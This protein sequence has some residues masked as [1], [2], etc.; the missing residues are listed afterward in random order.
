MEKLKEEQGKYSFNF[1]WVLYI[2]III[3]IGIIPLVMRLTLVDVREVDY[4]T[5][6][7]QGQIVDIFS[8]YKAGMLMATVAAMLLILF[9][10]FNKKNIKVDHSFK[11]MSI[12]A[13]VYGLF[14]IIS[15]SLSQYSEIAWWGVPDRAEGA[16]VLIAYLILMYYTYYMIQK[17]QHI[18]YIIV[19][20]VI[21]TLIVSV[22][23]IFQYI[24]EDLFLTTDL[25]KQ[26][27]VPKDYAQYRDSL[28]GAYS[29]GKVYGTM[30]HYNYAGSFGAMIVPLFIT[31][32]L[33]A[34]N[35][36][37]RLV[38]GVTTVCSI[39]VLFGSTSRA[40]LIGLVISSLMFLV[41]FFKKIIKSW[42]V[43]IPLTGALVIGLFVL[44][45]LSQGTLFARIPSLIEDALAMTGA[46]EEQVDY[47]ERLPI[48]GI[49]QEGDKVIVETS[50][51][52]LSII[53]G[54]KGDLHEYALLFQDELG[55]E[56]VAILNGETY[57]L[58]DDRFRNITVD[59]RADIADGIEKWLIEYNKERIFYLGVEMDQVYYVNPITYQKEVW[60]E[61]PRI[62]FYGKE[63][64]GSARGYIWS[65]SLP[66][67]KD[68][69]LVGNGPD[70]YTLNFPQDD[71]LGKWAAYD[72]TNM[73]VDKPHNLYLQI[74]LN[75]GVV[76]LIGFLTLVGTYLVQSI[77]LYALKKGYSQFD[78]MGSAIFLGIVGYLGAG[79]FND[80]VVS[81]APIFWILLGVGMA[82]NFLIQ[83]ER[84]AYEKTMEHATI[85]MKK[86]I[87]IK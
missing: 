3:G 43:V 59:K 39:F 40:G 2:P 53:S 6:F 22:L 81:V 50:Q 83:Q 34:K 69:L 32:F 74:A 1:S 45:N 65:R 49:R 84:K 31:L 85:D 11:V 86:R 72:T 68:T 21:L 24:G 78:I 7:N 42:K 33:F 55:E 52:E 71:Y 29:A 18:K 75:Q 77:K 47:K 56:I 23:G 54:G 13:I 44:N 62:G 73:I 41:I 76:A 61:A 82:V 15:A 19:P 10:V 60:E 37:Y 80:S 36:K 27:I 87:Y 70:T 57:T 66:L 38:F 51:G 35:M 16:I 12:G 48:Q 58:E 9:L 20:L 79:L 67:L 25:G 46:R 30:Y 8:Q 4:A 17:K 26:I 5:L 63:R 28:S 64:L 14:T